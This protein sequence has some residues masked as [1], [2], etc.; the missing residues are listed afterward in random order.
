MPRIILIL[1]CLIP[2]IGITQNRDEELHLPFWDSTVEHAGPQGYVDTFSVN[3]CRF[4]II[5]HDTLFDGIVEKYNDG[6]WLEN[7]TFE[8]LG[9]HNDYDRT[10]DVNSDGYNDVILLWKWDTEIFL[11]NNYSNRFDS[12]SIRLPD[13]WELIDTTQ[14]IFCNYWE[15][16]KVSES[17]SDLYTFKG[18]KLQTLFHLKFI[19][20]KEDEEIKKIVLFKI[21]NGNKIKL[22]ESLFKDD[23]FDYVEYWLKNYKKLLGYK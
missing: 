23:D 5:H 3:N 22:K 1:L 10:R 12:V 9:N 16:E 2:L 6:K 18:N 11:F 13:E 14:K 17:Y 19:G 15:H 7:I 20:D 4:R 8:N 21:V